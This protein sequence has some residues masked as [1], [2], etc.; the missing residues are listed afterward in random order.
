MVELLAPIEGQSAE[1][2]H[3]LEFRKDLPSRWMNRSG[4]TRRSLYLS[5]RSWS[6]T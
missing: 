2:H 3:T 4:S 5:S 1:P 6:M